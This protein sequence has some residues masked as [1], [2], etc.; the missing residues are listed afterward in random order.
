MMSNIHYPT[1]PTNH[2]KYANTKCGYAGF[3]KQSTQIYNNMFLPIQYSSIP[4]TAL[5][6]PTAI[7]MTP[8]KSRK[9]ASGRRRP[10]RESMMYAKT[11]DMASTTAPRK[12]FKCLSPLRS[13]R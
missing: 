3:L 8:H 2:T 11:Y 10:N 12:K 1:K 6:T 7:Q 4:G 9:P 13:G 5:I